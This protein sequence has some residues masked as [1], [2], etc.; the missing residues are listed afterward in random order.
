LHLSLKSINFNIAFGPIK[1]QR[2]LE[3]G[4]AKILVVDDEQ[5]I[6]ETMKDILESKGFDVRVANNGV[7]GLKICAEEPIDLIVLDLMMP[8]M[9]GYMFMERLHSRW[10]NDN[11][12]YPYPKILIL[13]ALDS[14]TDFG[15]AEN[16]GANKFL[17][18]P[19]KA[20]EFI[21]AIS[22]LVE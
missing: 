6:C 19:F 3:M 17:T 21:E 16:L 5:T 10:E 20:K 9:D 2:E 1:N 12:R 13:S 22:S 11:R 15:L 14:K 18:K 7:D 4:K 8:R